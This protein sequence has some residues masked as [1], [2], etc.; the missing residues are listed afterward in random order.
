MVINK[1]ITRSVL[2]ALAGV[3][4]AGCGDSPEASGAGGQGGAA[5]PVPG[6]ALYAISTTLIGPAGRT[7]FFSILGSL[8][9]SAEELDLSNA[10]EFAGDGDMWVRD[11]ELFTTSGESPTVIKNRVTETG[12]LVEEGRLSFGNFGVPSTAFS[13]NVFVDETKAYVAN[14]V[15]QLIAWNPQT[16]EIT[17]TLDIPEIE[18]RN[19]LFPTF[20]SGD[21]G[22]VIYEGQ[23]FQTVYWTDLGFARF[24]EA[25]QIIVFDIETDSIVDIIDAPCP[26]LAY[27]TVDEEG[28]L[29][30]SPWTGAA[31][32]ALVLGEETTCAAVVDAAT[33]EVTEVLNFTD[34][35]DGREGAAMRYIGNGRFAMSIFHEEDVDLESAIDEQD[36]FSI[37]ATASWQ[38][39]TYEAATGSASPVDGIAPNSGAIY[40]FD[41]DGSPHALVPGADYA[42]STV[43]ALARGGGEQTRL[44]DYSGW[45]VRL[46]RVR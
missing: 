21:R 14:G 6:D 18:N 19:G 30:F 13:A 37:L 4:L 24:D 12:E 42:R 15:Q 3:L 10:F 32:S 8:R 26:G 17:G 1:T 11:G 20:G 5:D 31:G 44:F 38:V 29:Y 2:L 45:A 33:R 39:W 28:N 16:M 7:S 22:T 36:P 40:W 27:G 25:S 23:V 34:L 46:F 41:V 9:P 35:A 43:Y